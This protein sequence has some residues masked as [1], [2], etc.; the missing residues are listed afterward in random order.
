MEVLKTAVLLNTKNK[1]MKKILLPLIVSA[2]VLFTA[3][4][5]NKEESKR[6]MVLLNDQMYQN[7]MNSDTAVALVEPVVQEQAPAPQA[8]AYREPVARKTP[9]R[10]PTQRPVYQDNRPAPAPVVVT[11]PTPAPVP[12]ATANSNDGNGNTDGATAGTSAAPEEKKKKGMSKAAQGA[13]IGGVGGA[14]GGAVIG[15]N[16]KG[17]VIGGI[18]G[19]AGGY[20]LGKQKDK[21]DNRIAGN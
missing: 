8:N 20:I 12:D 9:A 6:D 10:R 17:A 1:T 14:V 21:K 5:S 4:S 13:I 16:G 3:C 2:A 15:K 11:E 7:S 19:A 18:I